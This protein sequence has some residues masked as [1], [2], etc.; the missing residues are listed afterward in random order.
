MNILITG[1]AGFL[2]QQLAAALVKERPHDRITLVDIN[3]TERFTDHPNITSLTADICDEQAVRQLITPDIDAVFHLAAIV[4][5]HA[6][7]DPD[8]GYRIN[9]LATHHLLEA[10]RHTKPS[11]RLIFASSLAVFGGKLPAVIEDDT[12]VTPQGTY[13]TQKAMAELLINDYSRKGFIDGLALRLP[14]ICIRPG[15]PNRAASSFVSSIM[16]EPLH[17]ETAI[18]PVA[19]DLRLWLSSPDIVIKN[20]L[21]ALT[22]PTPPRRDWHTINLPGITVSVE[23]MLNDLAAIK[24]AD[25]LK[26]ITTAYDDNINAIV[27]AWPAAINTATANA[28]GFHQDHNFK[29]IIEQYL[30]HHIGV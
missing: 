15:K 28:L 26:H 5:S 3:P 17:G 30:N 11:I 12:A 8:L 13:G 1:G 19:K 22:L 4:S 24:G 21:H 2:G 25:V 18:L 20:F 27:A 6:E 16:R 29:N 14:T 23:E 10:I 7:A 9:F